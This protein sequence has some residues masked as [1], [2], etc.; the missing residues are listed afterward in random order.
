MENL[1]NIEKYIDIVNGFIVTYG[2]K[3]V[4]AIVVLIFGLWI[5]RVINRA[6]AKMLEKRKI[7]ASLL[8][9]FKSLVSIALKM[10][11]V[12]AVLGMLGIEM[13]S[14]VALLGAAGFAMGMALSGTLSN[15]AGGIVLL[16]LR[17]FKVGDYIE[18]Q[19][20]SGSVKAIQVF[21]T[22]LKTIDN[23]IITIP[24]GDLSTGSIVN[25]TSEPIRRCDWT[26]GIGYGDDVEK[27]RKI[28][29]EILEGDQRVLSEPE[30]IFIKVAE[31]GDSSV[32]LATRVWVKTEDYWGLKMDTNEKVYNAFNSQGIN[33]PFP[34]MDV[35]LH[36]SN[37]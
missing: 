34:Q 24:N 22:V 11:L 36:N 1:D 12:I 31:L 19:G 10:V 9:F 16:I 28:L 27:A 30:P 29:M 25:F 8:P 33:I 26:F 18:A 14:L 32:N 2:M 37:S 3:L 20:H 6:F 23:R 35:H 17:P 5:V 4:G 15:F 7:D 21:F 13:T